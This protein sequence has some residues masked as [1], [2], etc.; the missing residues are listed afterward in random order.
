MTLL[1]DDCTSE[2]VYIVDVYDCNYGHTATLAFEAVESSCCF[3]A[4]M[5]WSNVAHI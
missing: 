1:I 2:T 5:N 4:C 3:G